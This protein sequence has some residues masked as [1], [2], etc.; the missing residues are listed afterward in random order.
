MK[1]EADAT[2]VKGHDDKAARRIPYLSPNE[3]FCR[4]VAILPIHEL[5]TEPGQSVD[6]PPPESAP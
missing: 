6:P 4:L 2:N 3:V 1:T 5:L